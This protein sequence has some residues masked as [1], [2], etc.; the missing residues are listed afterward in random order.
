LDYGDMF[1]TEP[2]GVPIN[3]VAHAHGPGCANVNWLIPEWIG[4]IKHGS[5]KDTCKKLSQGQIERQWLR[6]KR[7]R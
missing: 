5:V 3:M 6:I 7:V 1:L 4:Q 2:D